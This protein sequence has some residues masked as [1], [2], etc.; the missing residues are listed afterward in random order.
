MPGIAR[1]LAYQVTP[2]PDSCTGTE[3]HGSVGASP[4]RK[5][6]EYEYEFEFDWGTR[7]SEEGRGRSQRAFFLSRGTVRL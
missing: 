4:Y 5:K 2:L 1:G 7:R 6:T 3:D